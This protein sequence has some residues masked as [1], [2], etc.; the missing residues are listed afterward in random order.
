MHADPL[1]TVEEAAE[2]LGVS[3]ATVRRR[4]QDG[5]LPAEKHGRQWLVKSHGLERK[6]R[7]ARQPSPS[8]LVDLGVSL[9]QLEHRDLAE[10][11]VPDILWW[12]DLLAA[13]SDVM[14]EAARRLTSQG[15][16]QPVEQVEVP[17][18][19]FFSRPAAMLALE[20]RLA[21]HA[22]VSSIA[23]R[24]EGLLSPAV[25]SAR[26]SDDPSYLL[27]NGRDQWLRWQAAQ[28]QA[29]EDGYE[30]VVKTDITAYFD[31]IEHRLLF[32]DI[33]RLNPDPGVAG[34]LKRMLGEW[35]SVPGRGL[36]QGP[37]ASR[38]LASLYLVPV[39]DVLAHGD[40]RYFRFMDDLRVL[41]RTR[42]EVIQGLRL[43][44]REC[45]RRGLVLSAHKTSLQVG[46]EARADLEQPD[47]DAV[48]YWLEIGNDPVARHHLREILKASLSGAGV[49]DDRRAKFSLWRLRQ[50]RDHY[51]VRRVLQN[52]ERLAPIAPIV[53]Q[54]LRPFIRR[55]RVQQALIEFF[56]DAARNDSPYTSTWL[57]TLFLE[58]VDAPSDLIIAYA[59]QVAHDRNEPTFH[60]IVAAN[61]LSL[62]RR[63]ADIAWLASS[64][65]TDYDPWLVRGYLVA[66]ARASSLNRDIEKAAV[67]RSPDLAKTVAYL[68]GRRSLP[69]LVYRSVQVPVA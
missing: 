11:W 54:Y 62:G 55:A 63:T 41:G 15:R 25:F 38:V 18:N 47:L 28:R 10:L 58:S 64:A 29:I 59:R 69:S 68:T 51:E 39:D 37:D 56:R 52:L 57:L 13:R 20:D 12:A 6:A 30:W 40:W 8:T 19:S 4:A 34:A 32:A 7:G 9:T 45:R 60:R 5:S 50:L 22:A 24:I 53:A 27:V 26:L 67:M 33:D 42:A 48:E 44:E 31:N 61:V 16:C 14:A 49:V 2:R 1:L 65:K 17:K 36:P 3:V 23:P 46:D 21:Y 43:L 66:L 35:A